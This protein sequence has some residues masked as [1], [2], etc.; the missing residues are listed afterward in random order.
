MALTSDAALVDGETRLEAM[1]AEQIHASPNLLLNGD[2][3]PMD[4]QA[5]LARIAELEAMVS[6]RD[7]RIAELEAMAEL[8]Q[9]EGARK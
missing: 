2:A 6:E 1:A 5:A 9:R 3:R 4:L 8:P 7:A